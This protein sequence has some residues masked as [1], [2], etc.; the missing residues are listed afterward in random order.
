M[1]VLADLLATTG[2]DRVTLRLDVAGLNYPCVAECTAP[3][4][5]PLQTDTS[6][7]QRAAATATW[8]ATHRGF[9]SSRTSRVRFLLR[10]RDS[11]RCTAYVPRCWPPRSSTGRSPAGCPCTHSGPGRGPRATSR[12]AQDT[13]DAV[14]AD[15]EPGTGTGGPDRS[16]CRRHRTAR[17]CDGDPR[18]SGPGGALVEHLPGAVGRCPAR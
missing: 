14:A 2:A 9:S 6:I 1:T 5:V 7:D 11:C 10:R 18:R 8:M 17:G 4:V 12:A 3:G 15:L 13:A 16:S